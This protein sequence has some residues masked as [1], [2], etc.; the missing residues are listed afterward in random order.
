MTV[1]LT[2]RLLDERGS[3]LARASIGQIRYFRDRKVTLNEDDKPETTRASDL[4]AEVEMRPA[5]EWRLRAGI[6][7]DTGTDR[8]E[9]NALNLRYQPDRRSVVNVGYRLVRDVDPTIE[10]ADL[11]F[12]WP[13]GANLRTV[14]RWSLALNEDENRTLKRSAGWSTKAAAGECGSWPAASSAAGAA[15]TAAGTIIPTGSF[16]SSSSRA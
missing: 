15:R 12:A 8:T 16:F 2:S 14:G 7:Y 9:K 10:Q 3:E 5:R 13:L 11:S 1:S 6:Q 4:V